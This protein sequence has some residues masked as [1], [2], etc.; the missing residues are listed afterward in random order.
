ALTLVL[1]FAA[2]S[3]PEETTEMIIY[4][5]NGTT[6]FG[7]AKLMS[8][9]K[10]DESLAHYKFQVK[11]DA[12]D[13][14]SALINGDAD[15][16]A[17]PTNAASNVYNKTNGAVSV[18]AVN[19]LGCL[20]LLT[21]QNET[22]E[23]FADLEGKTVYAPA[24]NPT[25]ILKYL[26]EKNGLTVGKDVIIDSTSYAAPAALKDAVATGLVSI[27]VLPEP[28]VTVATNAA[29]K[30]GTATIT[31][32]L[33]LTEEWNRVA[34]KDTLVQGCIVV[35]NEFL[36]AHP[37][38]VKDFLTAYE[39]SINYLETNL[40]EASQMIVDCGIFENAAVAKAAIPKCNV[41]YM[42]GEEM[43]AAMKDYLTVLFGINPAAVG[44][45]LPADDF[46]YVP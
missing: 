3:A 17:L 43:K 42:D 26:C 32:A 24:Q 19:T 36:E 18:L 1:P 29:K 37:E 41:C 5:L 31:N 20:Y 4:T 15:I 9:A 21:N 45:K 7:M 30:A 11:T 44:N 10:E 28:M 14:T 13:V 22:V 33:D 46:Y 23:S 2:C 27:A 8:D 35:R 16:A 39:A 25:F 40:E 6:G 38:A 34:E 12:S